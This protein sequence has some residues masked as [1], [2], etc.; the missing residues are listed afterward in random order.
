MIKYTKRS[1]H[2]ALASIGMVAAAGTAE[3]VNVSADGRGQV[4]LYPYYT[5]RADSAGNAYAT[6]LSVVNANAVAKAVRVRFLEGRNGRPVLDSNLFLSPFDVWTAAVVPDANTGGAKVGTVDRSCT[7]PAFSASPTTPYIP[8]GNFSYAG[9]NDDGAGTGS[10]RAKEGYFEI[11][12]MASYAS[13][14]VTARAITHVPIV[15][16]PFSTPPCGENLNDIQAM[17]DAQL[18]SGGLFGGTTLINVNSGTDYTADA[19]A[20]ANFYQVGANYQVLGTSLPDLTQAAPPVSTIRAPDGTLYE[21]VWSN[22]SADAVSALLMHDSLMNEYVL[23]TATKSG[24]DWVVTM[25]TKRHY[26]SQ[27]SGNASKLFQRNFNSSVGSCD[28]LKLNIFDREERTTRPPLVGPPPPAE[29]VYSLCWAAT[30]VAV[31]GNASP[32]PMVPSAV[33]GS[34]NVSAVP[35]TLLFDTSLQAAQNGWLNMGFPTLIVG[36]NPNVHKLINVGL[37]SISGR[38]QPTTTA[39]TTTYVGLPTIGFAA[40]SFSNGTVQVGMPPTTVLSNYG[41]NFV[42]KTNTAIK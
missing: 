25:P 11:I 9:A 37:T 39:N 33:F 34:T 22:G 40:S 20:L 23:D 21:S 17:T 31:V 6:L 42:H 36:A 2:A 19:V 1:L 3:A 14:S 26:V 5:T 32:N 41:S 7:L 35:S 28:D 15:P 29:V 4:L 10:D 12:E 8:F 27:G 13:S 18:P 16:A 30:V 38:G 24:T